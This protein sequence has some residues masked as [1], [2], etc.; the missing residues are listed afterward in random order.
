MR[1]VL[2]GQLLVVPHVIEHQDD[3]LN[4]IC[5]AFGVHKF[6]DLDLGWWFE[7]EYDLHELGLVHVAQMLEYTILL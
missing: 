4:V 1:K 5:Y 7:A 3:E 6:L 2:R